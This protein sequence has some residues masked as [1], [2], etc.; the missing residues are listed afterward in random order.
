[1][2]D[3]KITMALSENHSGGLEPDSKFLMANA[4]HD[5]KT[6]RSLSFSSS[7]ISD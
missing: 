7:A 6:V 3:E 5:L 4:A 2:G 1:M